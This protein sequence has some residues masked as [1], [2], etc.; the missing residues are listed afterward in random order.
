[1]TVSWNNDLVVFFIYHD[2]SLLTP[3]LEYQVNAFN[4]ATL[5]DEIPL[6]RY[7]RSYALIRCVQPVERSIPGFELLQRAALLTDHATEK[8]ARR[9][10]KLG[11]PGSLPQRIYLVF[12][13]VCSP[14][15]Q[16]VLCLNAQGNRPVL[17]W[18]PLCY[19]FTTSARI[20][21]RIH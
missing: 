19:D 14:D 7:G 1:M 17:S 15:G 4:W 2:C 16:R 9:L 8:D 11:L 20:V 12:A 5:P 13:G 3:P 21:R 18:N 10:A 6:Q